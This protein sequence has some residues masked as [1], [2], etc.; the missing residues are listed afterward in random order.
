MHFEIAPSEVTEC[1]EELSW[2]EEAVRVFMHCMPA[3]GAHILP[4]LTKTKIRKL[5]VD[6][7]AEAKKIP[8]FYELYMY[9]DNDEDLED[10]AYISEMKHTLGTIAHVAEILKRRPGL[11]C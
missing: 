3:H 5:L 6:I 11:I 7:F 2:G 8:E 10:Y 9:A 1:M 4:L